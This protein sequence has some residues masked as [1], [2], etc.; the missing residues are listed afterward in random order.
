[1]GQVVE[2]YD[3]VQQIASLPTVKENTSS[4]FFQAGKRIGDKRASVAEVI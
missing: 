4:P 1:M 2:G 3:L